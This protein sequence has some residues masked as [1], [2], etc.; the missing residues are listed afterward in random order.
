MAVR[1]PAEERDLVERAKEDPE[2]FGQLYD[3]YFDRI[4]SYVYRKVGDRTLAEDLTSDTFYKAL[5]HIKQ[6]RYTGQPFAA[7]LFR[8]AGNTVTDHFRSRRPTQSLD[9][10]LPLASDVEAPEEAALR[11]DERAQIRRVLEQLTPEQQ[12]VVLLRFTGDL[13]LKDIAEI[14]G[15]TEG[16]VKALMFRALHSLKAKLVESGVRS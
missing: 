12:D 6:Y 13:P 4:Y 14:V 3:L 11:T 15:K 8:I 16:A 1:D 10:G 7:W 2:A 9:T 5:T